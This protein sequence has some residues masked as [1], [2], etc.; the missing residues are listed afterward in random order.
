MPDRIRRLE[1]L[2]AALLDGVDG[3]EA[4]QGTLHPY[5]RPEA[6]DAARAYLDSLPDK[7]RSAGYWLASR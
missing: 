2:V 6:V 7:G 5:W 1:R 3:Y 4:E